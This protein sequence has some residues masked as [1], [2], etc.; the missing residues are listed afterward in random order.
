MDG[1]GLRK[2]NNPCIKIGEILLEFLP[3]ESYC[4][5]FKIFHSFNLPGKKQIY[6][7]MSKPLNSR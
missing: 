5:F 1:T 4:L 7:E 3:L 6:L 2:G